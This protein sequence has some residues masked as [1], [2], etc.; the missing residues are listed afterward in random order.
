MSQWIKK[1]IVTENGI[2]NVKDKM[3]T[4]SQ[5]KR[6]LNNFNNKRYSVDMFVSYPHDKKPYLL[7]N[8]LIY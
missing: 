6:S 3:A 2:Q 7:K 5:T 8:D 1:W 4:T